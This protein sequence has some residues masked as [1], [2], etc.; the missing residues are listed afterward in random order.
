M[1]LIKNYDIG[2]NSPSVRGSDIKQ[3]K[4]RAHSTYNQTLK[5][6][7]TNQY[8]EAN[9]KNKNMGSFI[10]SNKFEYGHDPQGGLKSLQKDRLKD[11]ASRGDH[12][13]SNSTNDFDPL[14]GRDLQ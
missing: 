6:K 10:L 13:R 2:V 5:G 3:N 4:N 9:D 1:N 7:F 8:A 11:N 14:R 12:R